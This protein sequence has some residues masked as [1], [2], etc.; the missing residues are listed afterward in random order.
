MAAQDSKPRRR[1]VTYGKRSSNRPPPMHTFLDL[2]LDLDTGAGESSRLSGKRTNGIEHPLQ[3]QSHDAGVS[4]LPNEN[5]CSGRRS[6]ISPNSS[7]Q[8]KSDNTPNDSTNSSLFD[9]LSSDEDMD[10]ALGAQPT[11]KRRKLTPV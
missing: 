10:R 7:N 8:D 5:A 2:D 9:L 3:K 6:P 1:P 4:K 11:R